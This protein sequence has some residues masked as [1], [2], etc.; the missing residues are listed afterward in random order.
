M[1]LE[2]T[3][4]L[5]HA[6]TVG[7]DQADKQQIFI[8]NQ[9]DISGKTGLGFFKRHFSTSA[10][11]EENRATLQAFQD[12]ILADP[13]YHAQLGTEQV[14]RFFQTKHEQ[15]AP[16]T[17]QDVQ[18]VKT[19]LDIEN[20]TEIGIGLAESGLI[21]DL[22]ALGFAWFCVGNGMNLDAPDGVKDALKTYYTHQHC[23]AAAKMA[24][25][26][27][28]VSAE[29]LP[30]AMTLLKAS[31]VWNSALSAA[32][33]SDLTELTH[34]GIINTFATNLE[35]ATELLAY[36]SDK[37]EMSSS[38]L[39]ETALSRGPQGI[40]LFDGALEA[41]HGGAIAMA[42]GPIFIVACLMDNYDLRTPEG[43]HNA[44]G[45]YSAQMDSEARFTALAR[46][47]GLPEAVGRSLAYNP[48]FRGRLERAL[49][50]VSP[51]PAIPTREMIDA[52][53][54]QTAAEF[55]VEKNEAIRGLLT[56]P[57]RVADFGPTLQAAVGQVDELFV[58]QVLNP[59]LAAPALLNHLLDPQKGPDATLLG[60]LEDF[61]TAL[62]LCQHTSDRG[63]RGADELAVS[64]SK[65]L[66]LALGSIDPDD[67]TLA[68]LFAGAH[69][70][71][72][73]IAPSLDS[74]SY[75]MSSG[76]LKT[77]NYT[78]SNTGIHYTQSII[79]RIAG[80]AHSNAT[81]AQKE[82]LGIEEDTSTYVYNMEFA[83]DEQ[84]LPLN[85]IHQSVRAFA[86]AHG[87]SIIQSRYRETE[88]LGNAEAI[89]FTEMNGRP[90]VTELLRTRANAIA[91]EIG[92]TNFNPADLDSERTGALIARA[93]RE[94]NQ[95]LLTPAQARELSEQ[96]IREHLQELKPT[97]DFIASLPTA[98]DPDSEAQFVVTPAEKQS[99]LRT[100]PGSPLR[101]PE[102][103][104]AT[105]L[106]SRALMTPLQDL[107]VPGLRADDMYAPLMSISSIH[108][109]AI[110]P[111]EA[112]RK[113]ANEVYGAYK[114]ALSLALD[115]LQL[116]PDQNVAL[117]DLVSGEA[118]QEVVHSI[119]GLITSSE[120]ET[121][122]TGKYRGPLM[123]CTMAMDNLRVIMGPRVGV[124]VAE[125]PLGI[126]DE[127]N[128]NIRDI[129]GALFDAAKIALRFRSTDLPGHAAL[130]RLSP[131][132]T[133]DQW[134]TLMPI[135]Q[136]AGMSI[137][138]DY[139][140]DA[141]LNMVAANARELLAA[142][143]ANRGRP[144]SPAQIWQTILGDRAPGDITANN[145][146]ARMYATATERIYQRI[147][148]AFPDQARGL[149]D[150]TPIP[151]GSG[152]PFQTIYNAYLPG[153]KIGMEDLRFAQGGLST[154][155]NYGPDEAYGLT[156]DWGR[157]AP[158]ADGTPSLMTIH[159]SASGGAAIAHRPIPH[160]ENM[161]ENPIF[162]KI[163]ENC[164]SISRSDLQFRR[165][166]QSLSQASTVQLRMLS[167]YLPGFQLSEH[168]H[169]DST[170]MPQP[171]GDI[172]V[173]LAN[174]P[175]DRP[176]GAHIEITVSPNG[177]SAVT[178]IGLE[179]RG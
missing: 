44:I 154:L 124:Q 85:Q 18:T 128:R 68:L 101:D 137:K 74:V 163:I 167:E 165:V 123:G 21:P 7:A 65:C 61:Q 37:Q 94:K 20:A 91:A 52:L 147:E 174:A 171:N 82:A 132:L 138:D 54:E 133:H 117:F 114:T 53:I 4:L 49:L 170:V 141:A 57:G 55:L 1:A 121:Q 3:T 162:V 41:V 31:S 135:M 92:L 115:A 15:G 48:E 89:A 24:L 126:V 66:A 35:E 139:D 17:A 164:R 29:K 78:A 30:A 8:N 28:G 40:S 64:T 81:Q 166:M 175:N 173:R 79:R 16:L 25:T 179:T 58:C 22:D 134:D 107:V 176:F 9:G 153:A 84:R 95:E 169:F 100:I 43:L 76:K 119:A 151:L 88:D 110:N 97:M 142:A 148:A 72:S 5:Q 131:A 146:G 73:V 69:K 143:D 39:R 36:M 27:A 83:E 6:N 32:F 116:R 102:L 60:H 130:A 105:L 42:E 93:V 96:A 45:K 111:F 99:L 86:Q 155:R 26:A 23:D 56:L 11:L 70:N 144:L 140:H 178:D 87:V 77:T 109:K 113:A 67:E 149:K 150:L 62:V 120:F 47:N 46:D 14:S 50:E 38:F 152:I 2:L 159:T 33:A 118:G 108:I 112:Q 145:L 161:P 71:F 13:R 103:I 12:A 104:K 125:D 75:N 10:K 80:F 136:M 127:H 177:E 63:F 90:A 34:T 157:R 160:E 19:M 122:A 106:E 158:S 98:Q 129:P 156:T 51:P 172:I 59:L 168:S